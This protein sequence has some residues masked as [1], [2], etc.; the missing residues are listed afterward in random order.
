MELL[1]DTYLVKPGDN[2]YKI[3]TSRGYKNPGPIVAFPANQALFKSPQTPYLIRAGERLCIPWHP[4]L[5]RKLIATSEE[6]I[7]KDNC[8]FRGKTRPIFSARRSRIVNSLVQKSFEYG[9]LAFRLTK[10]FLCASRIA[11]LKSGIRK[12]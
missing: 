12:A 4:D 2:L 8:N 7:G 11:L 1:F 6:M 5:L 9:E 10:V 3:G